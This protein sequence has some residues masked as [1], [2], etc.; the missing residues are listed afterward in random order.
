MRRR[1]FI[2]GSALFVLAVVGA[3]AILI[4]F[5]A[6]VQTPDSVQIVVTRVQP[7][8]APPEGG[9][10]P[11]GPIETTIIFDAWFTRQATPLY[12]QMVSGGAFPPGVGASCPN[13][14]NGIPYYHY[15]LTFYHLGMQVATAIND[16]LACEI[17]AVEYP[18]GNIQ[19]YPSLYE[20]YSFWVQLHRLTGA[21]E[22]AYPA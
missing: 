22:P 13:P 12:Q 16:A 18:G 4:A 1:R 2:S 17:F 8:P 7:P 3:G 10:P 15:A 21:P 19:H 5:P 11:P 14:G 6:F 9:P 20:K